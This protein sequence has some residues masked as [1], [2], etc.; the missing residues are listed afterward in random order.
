M[1]ESVRRGTLRGTSNGLGHM[2]FDYISLKARH[3]E[4]RDGFPMSLSLRVHRALSWL[5][6]A[7]MEEED[8]DARFIFLWIAFNAAYAHEIHDRNLYSEQKVMVNFLHRLI[9]SDK[10]QLLYGILW[11]EFP[12][13][14][15]MFIDNK[16]VFSS[17]WSYQ[18]G[19]IIEGEWKKRFERSKATA[20]KA[21]GEMDSL[22]I[23]AVIFER[24]Y[25]LRNQLI[26]G[27]ATW[28][29]RVNRNQIRDGMRIMDRLVPIVIH[30]MMESPKQVWG[31]PSYPVVDT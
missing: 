17:F 20:H 21:L 16:Y 2:E 27:G 26:H 18:Q 8:G 6:R 14:I 23:L 11:E 1:Y 22:K 29:G 9:G 24:L 19:R 28:N 12:K 30:L 5:H 10:D 15:R 31:E 13:S 4:I 25:V 7:E 3:R